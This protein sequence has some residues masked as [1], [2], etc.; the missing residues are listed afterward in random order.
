MTNKYIK[1]L[2]RFLVIMKSKSKS[3]FY[4]NEKEQ[5]ATN[6]IE[7]CQKADLYDELKTPKKPIER[8]ETDIIVGDY[9]AYDC[10]NCKQEQVMIFPNGD[11]VGVKHKYCS[12]CATALDW[13]KKDE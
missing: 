13:R 9:T 4:D 6:L 5:I 7:A 11:I 12:E 8:K 2:D 1:T 10:P 3:T